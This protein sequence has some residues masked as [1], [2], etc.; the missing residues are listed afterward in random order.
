M[1]FPSALGA[2]TWTTVGSG[3][4]LQSD[5]DIWIGDDDVWIANITDPDTYSTAIADD[6]FGFVGNGAV[7]VNLSGFTQAVGSAVATD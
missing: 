3:V 6:A 7:Q 2:G 4:T 5:D 1:A